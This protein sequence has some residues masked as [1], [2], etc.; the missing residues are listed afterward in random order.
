MYM[1][2]YKSKNKNYR[3]LP[4]MGSGD[5]IDYKNI[6]LLSIFISDQGKILDRKTNNLTL[7]QQRWL[8]IAIKKAR[9]LSSLTF[10]N[11]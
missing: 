1:N 8:N 6:N 2:K 10:K 4:I 11:N 9:I 5:L 7:K 3:R